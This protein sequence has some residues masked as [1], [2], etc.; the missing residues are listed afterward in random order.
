VLYG[1]FGFSFAGLSTFFAAFLRDQGGITEGVIGSM[2]ALS[3]VGMAAGCLAWGY[4]SDRVGRAAGIA[5]VFLFLAGSIIVFTLSRSLAVYYLSAL[6]F[7]AAEPGV[8]VIVAAAC[9]DYVGARL[10]PAAVGFATLF[11]GV[12]QAVG[13][14]L[15]GSMADMTA[16]FDMAFYLSAAVAFLGMVGAF[17]LRRPA[18]RL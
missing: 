10:A 2:W 14:F 16:S 13:P 5:I 3:G 18:A 4:I 7:W 11:M 1:L 12:G 6:F 15:A 8:P 17:F 9:A